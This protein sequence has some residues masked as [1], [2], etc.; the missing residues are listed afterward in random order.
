MRSMILT[1]LLAATATAAEP[2]VLV[3]NPGL[4]LTKIDRQT[5]ADLLSGD[6]LS[7]S[8]KRIHLV[9]PKPSGKSLPNVTYGLL[10][11]SPPAYLRM[12]LEA[13]SQGKHF[14]PTFLDSS[15][16]VE[17]DIAR[18]PTAISLLAVSEAKGKGT[19]LIPIP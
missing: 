16:A 6:Q 12:V 14:D 1:L 17:A 5:A 4:A 3:V 2:L 13:K 11:I 7:L 9:L 15:E 8:G 18:D 19:R 10:S